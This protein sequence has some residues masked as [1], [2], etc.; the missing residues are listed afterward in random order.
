M[1]HGVRASGASVCQEQPQEECY[2]TLLRRI[3]RSEGVSGGLMPVYILSFSSR[4]VA[5]LVTS[6]SC[7]LCHTCNAANSHC[8]IF[9]RSHIHASPRHERDLLC[10]HPGMPSLDIPP[11][12]AAVLKG[13]L[14]LVLYIWKALK[15]LQRDLSSV[16]EPSVVHCITKRR[17]PSLTQSSGAALTNLTSSGLW[18]M[19][20]A[21]LAFIAESLFSVW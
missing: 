16:G 20:F 19:C 11:T 7:S 18:L 17:H 13:W 10:L 3:L 4:R 21:I 12:N 15:F 8:L 2:L 1:R 9:L 6:H 5:K 14:R